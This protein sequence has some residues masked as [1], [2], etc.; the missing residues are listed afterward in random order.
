MVGQFATLEI[1]EAAA[2]VFGLVPP[3]EAVQVLEKSSLCRINARTQKKLVGSSVS[4]SKDMARCWRSCGQ[5][6][7]FP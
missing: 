6:S 1:R 2:F 3:S 4:R 5:R 7:L